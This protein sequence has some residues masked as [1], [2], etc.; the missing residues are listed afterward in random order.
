MSLGSTLGRQGKLHLHSTATPPIPEKQRRARLPPE[1]GEQPEGNGEQSSKLSKSGVKHQPKNGKTGINPW[2]GHVTSER[3][4]AGA[5][6]QRLTRGGGGG[7]QQREAPVHGGSSRREAGPAGRMRRQPAKV[8]TATSG[9]PRRA[10]GRGG[11]GRLA[12]DPAGARRNRSSGD[13][14]GMRSRCKSR[15]CGVPPSSCLLGV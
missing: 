15:C 11:S 13:G 6:T 14:E 5:P 1:Q 10:P 8:A 9:R 4:S 7:A 3:G 12:A 2:L